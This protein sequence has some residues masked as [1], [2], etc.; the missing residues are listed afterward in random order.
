M[1]KQRTSNPHQKAKRQESWKRG[2]ERKKAVRE[3]QKAAEKRNRELKA[4][5]LPTPRD[6]YKAAQRERFELKKSD[7]NWKPANKNDRGFIIEVSKDGHTTLRDPGD[8]HKRRNRRF[9][10]I[11]NGVIASTQSGW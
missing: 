1:A 2:Q 9:Q 11:S 3:A 6:L 5:G 7:P 8:W 10:M 4:K